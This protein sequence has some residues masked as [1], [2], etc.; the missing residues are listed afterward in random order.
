MNHKITA[1]NTAQ[2]AGISP[3]FNLRKY[4]EGIKEKYGNLNLDSLDTSGYAYNELKLW[5]MFIPQ[6]VREINEVIPQIHEI[7]KEHQRRLKESN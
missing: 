1:E 7:P 3:E 5:R 2:I 6:N 4:R